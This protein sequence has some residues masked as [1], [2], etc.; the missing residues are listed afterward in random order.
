[1]TAP[2]SGSLLF[3]TA[4]YI[5]FCRGEGYPWLEDTRVFG[6]TVLTAVVAAEL[7]AGTRTHQ[8]KRYLDALC[9]AYQASG[10]FSFPRAEAWTDTGMLLSRARKT[11]GQMDFVHHFR[12]LLIALEA[13]RADATLITENARDF[14][15]CRTLLASSG[16]KMK[17]QNL[18]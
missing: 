17:L 9:Q 3:D 16:R 1:M 15:R 6:R 5:R 7:Y 18:A 11:L 2:P 14:E 8:E 10:H 4:I 13:V 12:D